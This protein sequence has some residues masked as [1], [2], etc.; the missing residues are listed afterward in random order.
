[1]D[2]AIGVIDIGMTNKKVAVYNS[3]LEQVDASYRNFPPKIIDGLET[4]DLEAMEDWFISQ[5]KNFAAKY[6]IKALSVSTHGGAFMCLDSSGRLTVPCVVYTHEPGEAFHNAFFSAF[7]SPG[8]LQLQTGT[9]ALSAFINTAQG[10]YFIKER[11]REDFKK[12]S[13]ILFYPQYWGYRFTGSAGIESTYL[14]CHSYL[15]DQKENRFSSVSRAMGIADLFPQ[16]IKMSWESLGTVSK[17]FAARTG[18]SSGAIVTMGIHDSNSSL[19][20]HFAKRGETGF[21]V[22]STGTWCVLMNPVREYAYEPDDIGKAVLF[23]ISAFGKPVKTANFQGG[24][25]FETWS[26]LLKDFHRRDDVPPSDDSLCRSIFQAKDCFLLPE[27]TPG[28]GQF[29]LSR[30]RIAE[31]G[32]DFLYPDIVIAANNRN[33]AAL[34]DCFVDYEKAFAL[35]RISLVMQTMTALERIGIKPGMDIFIE[36]GFRKDKAYGRLLSAAFRDNRV[37]LSD[38]AEAT[39][40]GAA[41]TAK[42]ALTG[43]PL[44]ALATDFDIEYLELEKKDMGELHSYRE[45]WLARTQ[46]E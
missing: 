14:G 19:L 4:Y 45:R 15:W 13:L 17:E 35:L 5:L 34:P 41:M 37:Y 27:L 6:P 10:L 32:R 18:L 7:G 1:M 3:A 24:L 8:E 43:Q 39:A 38:I 21:I 11:Y 42:M 30:A 2:F 16:K 22:N 25:E 33:P 20:P 9:P 26:R 40:L 36:G 44:A 28:S 46:E 31:K 12:T 23:N 29:P